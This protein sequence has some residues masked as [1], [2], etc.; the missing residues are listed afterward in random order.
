MQIQAT[1]KGIPT[2]PIFNICDISEPTLI[3]QVEVMV[4]GDSLADGQTFSGNFSSLMGGLNTQHS[5]RFVTKLVFCLADLLHLSVSNYGRNEK[6]SHVWLI[7][8]F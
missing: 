1:S 7:N 6:L 8:M 2:N 3:R 4:F 5:N